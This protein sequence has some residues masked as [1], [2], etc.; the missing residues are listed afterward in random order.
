ML[1]EFIADLLIRDD[2]GPGGGKV[3]DEDH[4]FEGSIRESIER[5]NGSIEIQYLRGQMSMALLARLV[6]TNVVGVGVDP[7]T[8]FLQI[9]KVS[10]QHGGSVAQRQR[11][12]A[13]ESFL[14]EEEHGRGGSRSDFRRKVMDLWSSRFESGKRI[15]RGLPEEEEC[16]EKE[17]H[18]YLRI[19]S[20][21]VRSEGELLT[22]ERT[23]QG[24]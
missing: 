6:A 23:L 9:F 1:L 24:P 8:L 18:E 21:L 20:R 16:G 10:I 17:L 13:E 14:D 7:P 2:R 4:P 22:G 11:G 15:R 5:S 3:A 12:V 19:E